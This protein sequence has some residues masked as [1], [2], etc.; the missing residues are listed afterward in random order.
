MSPYC[1]SIHL[2]QGYSRNISHW[3]A[4]NHQMWQK[5]RQ[6]PIRY[7]LWCR[8][9]AK[10]DLIWLDCHICPTLST[11]DLS[12][13]KY[14]KLR[15]SYSSGSGQTRYCCTSTILSLRP[16]KTRILLLCPRYIAN[17]SF[18]STSKMWLL[19]EC[20]WSYSTATFLPSLLGQVRR[21]HS[22]SHFMANW[23]L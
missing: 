5:W 4:F 18:D 3:G 1:S 20:S 13:Y 12:H 7:S 11:S 9:V 16:K 17:L 23:R 21:P 15:N 22:M 14:V 6:N 2:M 8:Q 10:Q 19:L